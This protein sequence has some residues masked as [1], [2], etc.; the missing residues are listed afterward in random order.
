MKKEGKNVRERGEKRGGKEE[1]GKKG[2]VGKDE[3]RESGR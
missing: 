3:G 2:E 1:V